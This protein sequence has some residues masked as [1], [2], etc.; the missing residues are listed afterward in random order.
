MR[1][2]ARKLSPWWRGRPRRGRA[3]PALFY[4]VLILYLSALVMLR[5]AIAFLLCR[6]VHF[7]G[8]WDLGRRVR[9][10]AGTLTYMNAEPEYRSRVLGVLALCIGTGPL[11]FINIGLMAESYELPTGRHHGDRRTVPNACLVGLRR[12]QTRI[13]Y[14]GGTKAPSRNLPITR[15]LSGN[16]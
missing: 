15:V 8:N 11:G 1:L 4:M 10:Y 7:D 16:I 12:S 9:S 2:S 14:F 5:R 6:R 13:D 3:A